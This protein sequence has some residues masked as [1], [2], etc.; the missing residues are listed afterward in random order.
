VNHFVEFFSPKT[1]LEP[2]DVKLQY[3]ADSNGH[4]LPVLTCAPPQSGMDYYIGRADR[5]GDHSGITKYSVSI[6][7]HGQAGVLHSTTQEFTSTLQSG[8]GRMRMAIELDK[9]TP[10]SLSTLAVHA[11]NNHG[12]G[13]PAI[14]EDVVSTGARPPAPT[15][16]SIAVN[17][18]TQVTLTFETAAVHFGVAKYV[19]MNDRD[20]VRVEE[21]V[22]CPNRDSN[23]CHTKIEF[24]NLKQNVEYTFRFVNR[25]EHE[26]IY[27]L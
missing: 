6:Q 20:G 17:S 25:S 8:D 9:M 22:H 12:R 15:N 16:L 14:I 1:P 24:K 19:A 5:T 10:G 11:V 21:D 18:P 27:S 3:E 2:T 26:A 4:I 23:Q 7:A 13:N